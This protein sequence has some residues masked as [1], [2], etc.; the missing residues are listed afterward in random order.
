MT[1]GE[2]LSNGEVMKEGFWVRFWMESGR[3][4]SV[5]ED[6]YEYLLYEDGYSKK[7]TEALGGLA[8]DWAY[9]DQDGRDLMR[10]TS[11]FEIVEKPPICWLQK[12]LKRLREEQERIIHQENLIKQ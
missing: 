3:G 12:E 11:G 8:Y 7:D 10:F 1:N 2:Q 5:I 4:H 9:Y 6:T